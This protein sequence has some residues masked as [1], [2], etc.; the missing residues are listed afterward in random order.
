MKTQRFFESVV[1]CYKDYL[2]DDLISIVL[3]GSRARSDNARDSDYDIFITAKKLP[4]SPLE[5]LLYIRK[6][7]VAKFEQK[8]SIIAKTP[9]EVESGFPPL[10][11]DL[12]IDGKILY[13][14]GFFKEKIRRIRKLIKEAGLRRRERGGEFYWEWSKPPKGGWKLDWT[15]YRALSR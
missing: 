1:R 6:P 15:G 9:K 13:D 11:L 7:I 2:G 10:F 14:N 8:I 5:R 12:G 4:R 3:F